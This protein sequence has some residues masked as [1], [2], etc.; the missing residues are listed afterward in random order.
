[1]NEVLIYVA[2]IVCG[3]L[4]GAIPV[5]LIITYLFTGKDVRK[6]GS[7]RIGGT[8]VMRAAG[9][10]AGALTGALDVLKGASAGWLAMAIAPGNVWLQVFACAAAVLGTIRSIFLAEKDEHGKWHLKGGAGGAV[11][12][13]GA[14]SLWPTAG[15]I[16]FPIGAFVFLIIGYA[17]LTTISIAVTSIIVF[18]YR[19][20]MLLS[21][22]QYVLYGVIILLLVLYALQ[23]NL[24]RLRKGTERMVGLRAYLHKQQNGT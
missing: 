13:G 14:I 11:S 4:L 16:I 8:N 1:M 24:E 20:L 17:S 6:I 7:G 10:V 9:W 18:G 5:G 19:A 23:P 12:F 22:W 21:P 15:I 2:G 3:Y